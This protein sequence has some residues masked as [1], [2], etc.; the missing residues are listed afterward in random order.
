VLGLTITKTN[1][2]GSVI[3]FFEKINSQRDI[4]IL[5]DGGINDGQIFSEW[6]RNVPKEGKE[7]FE[8]WYTNLLL[9]GRV[10]LIVA[11]SKRTCNLLRAL[12]SNG[13]PRSNG[14]KWYVRTAL[15]IIENDDQT[16]CNCIVTI[17]SE[18]IDFYDPI[19]KR[20]LNGQARLNTLRIANGTIPTLLADAG[21]R[22]CCISNY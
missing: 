19:N 7:W 9:S 11:D 17:I 22:I 14:D 10:Q 4:I 3:N 18:D 1:L 20:R 8:Y 12:F 15:T 6:K 5:D 16:Q 13:F 21:I 2:T